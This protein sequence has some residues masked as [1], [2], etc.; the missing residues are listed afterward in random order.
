MS[1]LTAT[2]DFGK[3]IPNRVREPAH[4]DVCRVSPPLQ[5]EKFAGGVVQISDSAFRVGHDDSFLDRIENRLEKT[6]LLGQLQKIILNVLRPD[7]PRRP[8]SFSTKPAFILQW[9]IRELPALLGF[10]TFLAACNSRRPAPA[11]CQGFP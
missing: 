11:P 6:F 5:A 4:R 1:R 3:A 2:S 9:Q 7:L 8:I 10:W